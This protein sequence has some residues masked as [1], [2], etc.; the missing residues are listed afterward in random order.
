MSFVRNPTRCVVLDMLE[1]HIRQRAALLNKRYPGTE[2]T[3]E[4]TLDLSQ[5]RFFV[6]DDAP[7]RQPLG[8]LLDIMTEQNRAQALF[9]TSALQKLVVRLLQTQA[10]NLLL[11]DSQLHPTHRLSHVAE[12]IKQHL[13][14]PNFFCC[15]K[16]EFGLTALEYIQQERIKTAKALLLDPRNTLTNVCFRTGFQDMSHFIRIVKKLTGHTLGELKHLLIA[17]CCRNYCCAAQ[18]RRERAQKARLLVSG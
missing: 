11:D 3:D 5:T 16:N 15:F 9:A 6:T 12:Y 13:S 14:K 17:N 18:T 4:W 8:R 2:P 10:R 1:Q 7:T